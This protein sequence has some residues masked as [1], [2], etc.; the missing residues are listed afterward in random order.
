MK[1]T[2]L[3]LAMIA[4]ILILWVSSSLARY[5]DARIGRFLQVDP[6][7]D[8][9]VFISPYNYALNN[10][11]KFADPDGRDVIL[12]IWA[13]SNGRI[14]HAGVAVTNYR[15]DNGKMV[16]DGTYTYRDLW[17]GSPVG[18][19][20]F[21]ENVPAV[22]NEV[23]VSK[24]QLINTD[25]TGS[26][27]YTPDGVVQLTTDFS[28][29]QNVLQQLSQHETNNQNYNGL[30]NNCSDFAR[31]GVE[32]AAGGK[33]SA[34]E[35]LTSKTSATTPNQLYKATQSLPKANV[36]KDPKDKVSKGFIEEL[37]GGGKRQK[38]A[39]KKVD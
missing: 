28:T 36:V 16:P 20:N 17:P 21:G 4:G 18:K 15:N 38:Q 19:E 12:V 1:H 24:D 22:Y 5:Y 8:R 39:E 26:E 31:T 33:V 10:P 3:R 11:L 32:A 35:Q 6:H 13:T 7:S 14:G 9:Y 2:L 23:T 30:T 29:D 34:S 37:S 25:V 27:G